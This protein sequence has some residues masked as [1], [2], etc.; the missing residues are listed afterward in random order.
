MSDPVSTP[1][2]APEDK[3]T[4]TPSSAPEPKPANSPK[5]E[6]DAAKALQAKLAV[7][8]KELKAFKD[9]QKADED[10]QK[11]AAE[12]L[13]E[14]EKELASAKR[15]AL[16]ERVRRAHG[17]ADK[18]YDAVVASGETEDDIKAVYASHKAAL[19]EYVKSQGV[20]PAPGSGTGGG[21]APDGKEGGK[22]DN[23]PYLVRL[24]LVEDKKAI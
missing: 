18:V 24:G 4:P 20:K 11:T 14:R 8:E 3:P 10:V 22:P 2:P 12:K 15:D 16:V 7:A 19:D 21:K 6:D 9:K 17:F 1:S 5:P 23:R 13:A